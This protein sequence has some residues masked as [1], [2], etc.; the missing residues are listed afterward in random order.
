MTNIIEVSN[1]A[2]QNSTTITTFIY[3]KMEAKKNALILKLMV[4]AHYQNHRPK[5]IKQLS[6]RIQLTKLLSIVYKIW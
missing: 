2:T 4:L 3:T 6:I 1:H 5:I